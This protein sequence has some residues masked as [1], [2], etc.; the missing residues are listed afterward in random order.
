MGGP[1]GRSAVR[2]RIGARQVEWD[3]QGAPVDLEEYARSLNRKAF[4][5]AQ[6]KRYF[7][8]KRTD[9]DGHVTHFLDC[10]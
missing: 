7:V 3:A 8:A 2:W 1:G 5:I 4:V 6:G 10:R 9:D